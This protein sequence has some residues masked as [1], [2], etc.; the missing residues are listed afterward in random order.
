MG[1]PISM[2]SAAGSAKGSAVLDPNCVRG[3]KQ[4]CTCHGR[5]LKVDQQYTGGKD[6]MEFTGGAQGSRCGLYS[7]H[8]TQMSGSVLLY[9]GPQAYSQS[10]GDGYCQDTKAGNSQFAH[11]LTIKSSLHLSVQLSHVSQQQPQ[12]SLPSRT[13]PHM[14]SQ[15]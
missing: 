11:T 15:P 4:E 13:Q 8:I 9:K 7:G 6:N 5:L 12:S 10:K 2:F 14:N 3:V 1:S